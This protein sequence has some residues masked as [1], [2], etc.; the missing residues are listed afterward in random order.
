MNA[1]LTNSKLTESD[2][3]KI[4]REINKEIAKR[5][6]AFERIETILKGIKPSKRG[7]AV[8]TIREDRASH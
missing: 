4:G 1:L 2:A 6:E 8:K 3:I 5:H 7:W